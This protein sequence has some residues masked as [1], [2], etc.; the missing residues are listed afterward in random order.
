MICEIGEICGLI[1]LDFRFWILDCHSSFI[2]HPSSLRL[3]GRQRGVTGF[4]V[5]LTIAV[6]AIMCHS[7]VYQAMVNYQ[8]GA[9]VRDT[10]VLTQLTDS[11]LAQVLYYLNRNDR[12]AATAPLREPFGAALI[13]IG[14]EKPNPTVLITAN[15]PRAK[16]P[17]LSRTILIHLARGDKGRWV[18]GSIE[19]K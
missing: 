15:C 19:S 9:Q 2:L 18:V 16:Q 12:P 10:I 7:I 13:E 1:V 6:L 8:M 11:A 3:H 4:C 5:I 17:R 14:D